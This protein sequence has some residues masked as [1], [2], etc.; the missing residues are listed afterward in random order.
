MCYV[1]KVVPDVI[2]SPNIFILIYFVLIS[3][4]ESQREPQT[5]DSYTNRGSHQLFHFSNIPNSTE[6]GA[7]ARSLKLSPGPAC[8]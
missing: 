6:P 1:N 2:Y 5:S 3:E 8:G 7:K 4:V